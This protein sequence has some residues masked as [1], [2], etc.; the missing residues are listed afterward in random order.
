MDNIVVKHLAGSHAYGTNIESSDTDVRGIFCAPKEQICTPFFPVREVALPDEEDGKLYELSHFMKLYCEGNPNILESLW[1]DGEDVLEWN[2]GYSTLRAVAPSLL[3]SKVAFTFSGYAISQL[4]RIKGHHKWINNPQPE[5][6][7][8]HKDYLKMVQNF[9][10]GKVMPRDFGIQHLENRRVV[11]Y[12]NNI[13]GVHEGVANGITSQG[14]FNLSLK[15]KQDEDREGLDNPLFIF[16]YIDDEYK[17]DKENHKNYWDWKNNRNESRAKLEEEY[18]FDTK[19][20]FHL[21]RLLRMAEEILTGEGV[22]VKR[23]VKR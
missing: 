4:K 8:K 5:E 20:A 3:S 9:T 10:K 16:R 12:G 15:Q 11:H 14:D 13:F 17:R 23:P 7:P 1:V 18:G 19:H 21:I 6:V 2:P 22:K